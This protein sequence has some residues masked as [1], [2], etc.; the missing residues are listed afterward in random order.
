MMLSQVWPHFL[1]FLKPVLTDRHRAVA[2]SNTG[3]ASVMI[4]FLSRYESE[5]AP[6]TESEVRCLVP[7]HLLVFLSTGARKKVTLLLVLRG[8]P[9]VWLLCK[10]EGWL[11]AGPE[12]WEISLLA[13][14]RLNPRV[15]AELM[16]IHQQTCSCA[17]WDTL[18]EKHGSLSVFPEPAS[19]Q[20][21]PLELYN[22]VHGVPSLPQSSQSHELLSVIGPATFCPCSKEASRLSFSYVYLSIRMKLKKYFP[23]FP[24]VP[25]NFK[26]YF[27]VRCAFR[28]VTQV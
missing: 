16:E 12:R 5:P 19:F 15:T 24:E 3:S 13:L 25:S 17:Q 9:W 18:S 7:N 26:K 8:T 11:P 21:E 23:I 14:Q 1:P 2:I 28:K 22:E 10:E 6:Q 4:F 27:L 20:L